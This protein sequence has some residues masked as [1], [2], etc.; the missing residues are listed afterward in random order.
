M[1]QQRQPTLSDIEIEYFETKSQ[2]DSL[3]GLLIKQQK[4]KINQLLEENQQL[5][6]KLSLSEAELNRLKLEDQ[7][8]PEPLEEV[9]KN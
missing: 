3:I 8:E 2:A 9:K 1:S 5:Q 4:L 6:S 7:K